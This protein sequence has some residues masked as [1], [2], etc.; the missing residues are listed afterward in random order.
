MQQIEIE[1][2]GTE[3]GKAGLASTRDAIVRRVRG[4]YLGDQEYTIA[5]PG[6]H[7]PIN[8]SEWPLL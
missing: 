1:V 7:A 4:R 5:L 3:T 8:S 6:N 2:I